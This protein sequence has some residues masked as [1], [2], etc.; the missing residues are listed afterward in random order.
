VRGLVTVLLERVLEESQGRRLR[1][2]TCGPHAMMAAV[3]E[4]ARRF[5]V[6]CEASL[7]A[8]MGCGYGVCLGCSVARSSGGY[9]YTCVD[10]PCVDAA[11]VDWQ[12][13]VF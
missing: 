8:P 4:L 6:P 10:G 2:Y 11:A 9:F 13:R 1:V 12:K 3:A 5:E 7:E